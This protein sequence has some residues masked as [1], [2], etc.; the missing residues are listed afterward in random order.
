MTDHINV[1]EVIQRF[2]GIIQEAGEDYEAQ[3]AAFEKEYPGKEFEFEA[4]SVDDEDA[5]HA[6]RLLSRVING[7]L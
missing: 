4:G 7:E 1:D 2:I 6:W 5:Y 3:K